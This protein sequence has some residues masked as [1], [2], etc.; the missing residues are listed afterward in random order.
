M[1]SGKDTGVKIEVRSGGPAI[2]FQSV[3]SQLYGDP[4]VLLGYVSTDE[5]ISNS[6]TFPTKA[7]VAPFNINPQIIMWDPATYPNVKT[8]ADL[9]APAPRCATSPARRTW[10]T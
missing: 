6:S 1:A 7:V 2:G 9:K 5:Q 3:T 10:T 4:N 8:I